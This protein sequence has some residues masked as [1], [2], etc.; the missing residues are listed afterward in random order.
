MNTNVEFL[1]SPKD[2]VITSDG[3]VGQVT[4]CSINQSLQLVYQL[5][6]K[7]WYAGKDLMIYDQDQEIIN[8]LREQ[9]N[10]KESVSFDDMVSFLGKNG[11]SITQ[12]GQ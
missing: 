12:S 11:Y 7:G 3:V 6:F 8:N 4:M 2:M 10:S 1:F 5:N 9:L